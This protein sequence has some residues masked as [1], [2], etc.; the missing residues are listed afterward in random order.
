MHEVIENN[1]KAAKTWRGNLKV[2]QWLGVVDKEM[3]R[4]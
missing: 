1:L 2:K 3:I 4:V